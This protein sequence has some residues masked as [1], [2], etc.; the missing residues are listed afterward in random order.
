MRFTLI[1]LLSG[2]PYLILFSMLFSLSTVQAKEMDVS[3]ESTQNEAETALALKVLSGIKQCRNITSLLDR[4]DCYDKLE[5][6]ENGEQAKLSQSNL[7]SQEGIIWSR[8]TNQ[9]KHRTAHDTA[10]LVTEQGGDNSTVVLTTPALGYQSPRPI[11]MLSC[12]DNI[13][14]MQVTLPHEVLNSTLK[15]TLATEKTSFSSQWFIRENQRILEASRGLEGIKE[16]Q[17]LFEG[18][19]LTISSPEGAFRPLVFNIEQLS[20]HIKP[21]RRACH[22]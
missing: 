5:L 6:G 10:F 18:E 19:R 3:G 13:T 17:R 12:I 15:V 11:L 8:A 7:K 16:I 9:E 14:R 2:S 22:W 1:S 21:L 4:V 20:Q